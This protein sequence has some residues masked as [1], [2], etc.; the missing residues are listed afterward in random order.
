MEE[1]SRPHRFLVLRIFLFLPV[2]RQSK[3]RTNARKRRACPACRDVKALACLRMGVLGQPRGRR[4]RFLRTYDEKSCCGWSP[5]VSTVSC[6]YPRKINT[7]GRSKPGRHT[8]MT[9]CINMVFFPANLCMHYYC[10]SPVGPP[11]Q[12]R[13]LWTS[14][15]W[16]GW[17]VKALF[18]SRPCGLEGTRLP[19][20]VTTA[21]N[22]RNMYFC[23]C[24]HDGFGVHVVRTR[25]ILR[26]R[27][28]Y[29]VGGVQQQAVLG[30]ACPSGGR[31]SA[32]LLH[33][34]FSLARRARTRGTSDVE[35]V[36]CRAFTQQSI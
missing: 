21:P 30:V 2:S 17:K 22:V 33:R 4:G 8:I 12:R 31:G 25:S 32:K 26:V 1:V 6:L 16:A 9:C 34:N 5:Q 3:N 19:S 11:E 27:G 10:T 15:S 23:L 24:S 36:S 35:F 7:V 29:C 14:N 28:G 13:N 18:T 20:A